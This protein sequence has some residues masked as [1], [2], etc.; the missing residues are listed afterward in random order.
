M[1]KFVAFDFK[2]FCPDSG[3]KQ[4]SNRQDFLAYLD[5]NDAAD[6]F[7]PFLYQKIAFDGLQLQYL[8]ESK[9]LP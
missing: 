1:I 4:V 5:E 8:H 7:L 6:V 3:D 2:L 9:V